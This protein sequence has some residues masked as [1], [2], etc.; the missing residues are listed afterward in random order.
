M[1]IVP[2][3]IYDSVSKNI[4]VGEARNRKDILPEYLALK[5]TK[6]KKTW[7]K[8]HSRF[9]GEGSSRIAFVLSDGRCLKIAKNKKGIAQNKQEYLNTVNAEIDGKKIP[10]SKYSCFSKIYEAD[11]KNWDA[12]VVETARE[13]TNDDFKRLVETIIHYALDSVIYL[14]LF[15]T[16]KY[17]NEIVNDDPVTFHSKSQ[18][19]TKIRGGYVESFKNEHM[20]IIKN[21]F[22]EKNPSFKNLNSLSQFYAQYGVDIMLPND[23]ERAENWGVVN[24]GNGDELLII[25]AGFSEQVWEEYYTGNGSSTKSDLK[26]SSDLSNAKTA[27]SDKDIDVGNDSLG[28]ASTRP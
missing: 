27:T 11:T 18:E 24:R 1:I 23:L 14:Y 15:Q 16:S 17:P 2:K 19:Y 26:F 20:K 4:S 9:V 3:E 13:A 25:D 7:L 12:L 28:N 6:E 22:A 21:I 5:T 10:A 8:E